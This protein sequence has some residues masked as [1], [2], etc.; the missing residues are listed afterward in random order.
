MLISLFVIS[1]MVNSPVPDV[2]P[3]VATASASFDSE[4]FTNDVED[5]QPAQCPTQ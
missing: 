3:K 4:M 1:D 2:K 5:E